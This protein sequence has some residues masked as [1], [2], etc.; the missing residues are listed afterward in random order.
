MHE[1]DDNGI[2]RVKDGENDYEVRYHVPAPLKPGERGLVISFPLEVGNGIL[3]SPLGQLDPQELRF[4]ALF[5]D[6]LDL[7]YNPL[8]GPSGSSAEEDFLSAAN[9]FQRT[10]GDLKGKCDVAY[11]VKAFHLGVFRIHDKREP[12]QWSMARGERSISF[13][14]TEEQIAGGGAI[15]ELHQCIPV[16]NKDVALA[17]VLEFKRRRQPE[18]IALRTHLDEIYA[19]VREDPARPLEGRQE[20]DKLQVAIESHL[21]VSLETKFPL[22]LSGWKASVGFDITSAA[23]A[24]FATYAASLNIGAAFL[25]AGATALIPKLSVK[26]D[27]GLQGRGSSESPFEYVSSYHRELFRPR[28]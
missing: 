8:T 2:V 17:D 5:W 22:R 7:P 20:I 23:S 15:I 18:L 12:N 11:A 4:S 14:G 25:A 28:T 10:A 6:V 3:N 9:M 27:I 19:K 16:P 26:S 21:K 13:I 24:G 1:P